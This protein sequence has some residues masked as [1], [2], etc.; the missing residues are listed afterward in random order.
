MVTFYFFT[1][2]EGCTDCT[3]EEHTEEE[4]VFPEEIQESGQIPRGFA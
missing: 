3:E 4:I 1:E 2:E